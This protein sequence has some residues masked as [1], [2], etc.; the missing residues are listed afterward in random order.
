MQVW[1]FAPTDDVLGEPRSRAS[2]QGSIVAPGQTAEVIDVE[3]DV[4]MSDGDEHTRP[5]RRRKTYVQSPPAG[6]ASADE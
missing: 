1:S 4:A 2:S 5:G 3:G 6:A